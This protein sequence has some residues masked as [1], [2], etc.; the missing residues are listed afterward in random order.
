MPDTTDP[1]PPADVTPQAVDGHPTRDGNGEAARTPPAATSAVPLIVDLDGTLVATD[2]LW[3]GYLALVREQPMQAVAAV[4]LVLHGRPAFKR[5][6]AELQPIDPASLPYR[7]E[8]RRL[9]EDAKADGRP[10]WLTT[11]TDFANARAVADHLGC[12]DGVIATNDPDHPDINTIGAN[13]LDLIRQRLGD[14]PFDYAG[15]GVVDRKLW[16]ESRHA[17]TVGA[18]HGTGAALREASVPTTAVVPDAKPRWKTLLKAMR[19]QQWGKNLLLLLP[20]FTGMA[21]L[22]GDKWL[23][24]IPAIA[25][26]CLAGSAVYLANDLIDLPADRAHPRKKNRALASGELPIPW[27]VAAAPVCLLGSLL[28]AAGL[29]IALGSSAFLMVLLTYLVVAFSYALVI[30]G[31]A[32]LDVI[33]LASLYVLRIIAGGVAEDLFPTAWLLAFGSFLFLSLAFA[34]RYAELAMQADRGDHGTTLVAGRGYRVDDTPLV[35]TMGVASG[36]LAVLVLAFYINADFAASQAQTNYAHP[37]RLWLITPLLLYWVSRLWFR[38]HRR[39]LRGDPLLFAMTDPTT[40]GIGALTVVITM[41][42]HH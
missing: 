30:K 17:Y 7:P 25:A 29:S 34:K 36:Y 41:W 27:G 28:I 26:F 18:K 12:F 39:T 38:A 37:E 15:D 21:M 9:I 5:R 23:A 20:M 13:K 8:I 22:D 2:T 33:C 11:G 4:P 6:V 1:N 19:P 16:K 31:V 24:V 42:A 14:G 3:E 40:Y 35:R 32:M 10:V